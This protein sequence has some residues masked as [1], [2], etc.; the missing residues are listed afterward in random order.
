MGDFAKINSPWEGYDPYFQPGIMFIV[1]YLLCVATIVLDLRNHRLAKHA[2]L[3]RVLNIL[4]SIDGVMGLLMGVAIYLQSNLIMAFAILL[5]C[6][7]FVLHFLRFP[8]C[9]TNVCM[10]VCMHVWHIL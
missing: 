8:N 5:S 3:H 10:Y 6:K 7:F 1:S 4:L 2:I 9:N